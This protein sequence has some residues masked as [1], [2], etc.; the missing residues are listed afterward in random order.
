MDQGITFDIRRPLRDWERRLLGSCRLYLVG[1][2]VRDLLLGAAIGSVDEDYVAAGATMEEV[3]RALAPF[4]SFDFVGKSF[5]VLKFT[6]AGGRTVDIS[7]PRTEFSTGLGHRE[8]SVRFDPSLPIERDLERRDFTIN[9]MAADLGSFAVVDPLGGRA[10]LAARV[11]RVNRDDSFREDPLRMLR[12]AQ[13]LAR[14]DLAPDERTHAQMRRDANLI[15]TVS[16]ERVNAELTKLLTLSARPS[17]GIL[18]MRETGLLRLVLPEL[19]RTFGETQNEYHP[20]DVFMH[21]L[22][23]CDLAPPEIAL[24]WSALLH[25]VGKKDRKQTVDGRV[26]FYRHEEDG[27]AAAEAI[28]TRLRYSREIVDRVAALVRHHMWNVTEE[29]S[30]G[31]VRR[32]IVRVGG[33]EM[34]EPLLALREADARSRGDAA[35]DAQIALVRARVGAIVEAQQALKITDLAVDGRDVMSV[36]GLR[37]GRGVG[38]VLRALLEKALDDPSLNTREKLLAE[39]KRMARDE[40]IKR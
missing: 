5:G 2:T 9:S 20:D 7:L 36:L 34:I 13:L 24:R 1:G 8:F 15:A 37:E 29:W 19:D 16:A 33:V 25:D 38:E 31:A 11:L 10:D 32:F 39:L 22:K 3:T 28:L 30:D 17:T 14:F 12:G 21:S 18:F 40:G 27:A 26:V 4:G 23:T 35:F 6:P